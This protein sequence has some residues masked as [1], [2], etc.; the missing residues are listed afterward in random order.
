MV[1][2]G[3][4][5]RGKDNGPKQ[6]LSTVWFWT[7]R[8]TMPTSSPDSR[9]FCSGREGREKRFRSLIAHEPSG[10]QIRKF[11]SVVPAYFGNWAIN[12]VPER[13]LGNCCSLI[14]PTLPP[15]KLLPRRSPRRA[16]NC[17]LEPISTRSAT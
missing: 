3:D 7:L 2:E 6:R 5:W 9:M 8:L 12:H 14:A 16:T 10:R 13:N 15:E 17:A 4:C 11:C 1:G